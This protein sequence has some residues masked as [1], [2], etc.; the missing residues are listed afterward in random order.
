VNLT[1]GTARTLPEFTGDAP[2]KDPMVTVTARLT[3]SPR[4]T[5]DMVT[6]LTKMIKH[7]EKLQAAQEAAAQRPH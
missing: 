5:V 7:L 3:L 1:F 6:T 2:T 4:A